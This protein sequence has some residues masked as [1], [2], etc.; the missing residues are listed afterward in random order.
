[1]R[2]LKRILLALALCNLLLAWGL[3]TEHR[4]RERLECQLQSVVSA[5]VAD[6]EDVDDAIQELRW[7]KKWR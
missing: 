7:L 6:F 1:M 3:I 2:G 5:V 4:A